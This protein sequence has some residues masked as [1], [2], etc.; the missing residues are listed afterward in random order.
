MTSSITRNATRKL[1]TAD[2]SVDRRR[3]V[4]M[5]GSA[6]PSE[7]MN[8]RQ[9]IYCKKRISFSSRISRPYRAPNLAAL[10]AR[11]TEPWPLREPDGRKVAVIQPTSNKM[12]SVP[13]RSI[14]KKK[15]RK[16]LG[17]TTHNAMVSNEN[18]TKITIRMP[19]NVSLCE[20]GALP[21][22]QLSAKKRDSRSSTPRKSCGPPA[23]RCEKTFF[24]M[25]TQLGDASEG[26]MRTQKLGAAA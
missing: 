10:V 11:S 9:G 5:V 19:Y 16:Y 18:N 24:R 21:T 15:D 26:N 6:A 22:T 14:Q 20:S 25:A 7:L 17:C 12:D 4:D 3:I 8:C 1:S 2:N 23:L 13:T